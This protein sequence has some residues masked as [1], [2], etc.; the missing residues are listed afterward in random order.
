MFSYGDVILAAYFFLS[1]AV[2]AYIIFSILKFLLKAAIIRDETRERLIHIIE[3]PYYVIT[4]TLGFVEGLKK[5]QALSGYIPAL[6]AILVVS[7]VL[8]GA[9]IANRTTKLMLAYMSGEK[10]SAKIQKLERTALMSLKNLVNIFIA[11]IAAIIILH[12]FNVDITPLVASLGIG[13]IAIALALQP[14]LTNYF[15]GVYLAADKSFNVGDYIEVD[16]ELKGWVEKMG[17]RSTLIRTYQGYRILMPNS[18]LAESKIDNY[19]LHGR[20]LLFCV[21]VG[22]AYTSDLEKVERVTLE[23]ARKILGASEGRVEHF[24]PYLFYKE[25]GDSNINFDVWLKVKDRPYKFSVRH[26]FIKQL[27]A[28]YVENGIEIAYPCTNVYMRQNAPAQ[29]APIGGGSS[30]VIEEKPCK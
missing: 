2:A 9:Y 16:Q 19:S 22:V 11:T 14:T 10:H 13:G 20:E 6:Q 27:M 25:F 30:V 18:K 29:T 17:W 3:R 8:L 26:Q 24:E 12:Q 15:A 1:I 28:A 7:W 23:V 21:P 5:I 4:L